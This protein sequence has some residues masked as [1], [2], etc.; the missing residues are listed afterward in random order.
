MKGVKD[1]VPHTGVRKTIM[2]E[3]TLGTTPS[4]VVIWVA[5]QV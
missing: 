2:A 5:I 4:S 3:C 1:Q